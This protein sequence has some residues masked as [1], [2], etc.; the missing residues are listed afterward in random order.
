MQSNGFSMGLALDWAW[1]TFKQNAG[2][3]LGV[4]VFVLAV[5]YAPDIVEWL[6]RRTHTY[7]LQK[8]RLLYDA[9]AIGWLTLRALLYLG[10]VRIALKLIDGQQAC[11][12]DLFGGAKL[13]LRYIG[14]Q[15]LVGL[16]VGVGVLLL[17]VPGIIWAIQYSMVPYLIVDRKMRVMEAMERSSVLTYDE[18]WNLFVFVLVLILLALA[19]IVALGLGLF[20]AYPVILLAQVHVYRQL[21]YRLGQDQAQTQAPPDEEPGMGTGT[22]IP[23]PRS[24]FGDWSS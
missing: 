21:A 5:G 24:G 12:G 13:L 14:A 22:P 20:V 2:L 10:E 16:I 19:G 9:I 17:I 4:S 18:K 23:M 1:E 11:F 7:D 3:L 15:I 6:L 8:N